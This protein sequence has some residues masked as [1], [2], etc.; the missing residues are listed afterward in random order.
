MV[1]PL[2]NFQY[3]QNPF[4]RRAMRRVVIAGILA[5]QTRYSSAGWT[6]CRSKSTGI[7][8]NWC[9]M[10]VCTF[11]VD[12]CFSSL[13]WWMMLPIMRQSE[14]YGKKGGQPVFRE[15]LKMFFQKVTFLKEKQL[16]DK[17]TEF[18]IYSYKK[19]ISIWNS[20]ITIEEFVEVEWC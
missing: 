20:P 9:L 2:K 3:G 5:M 11:T 15:L 4:I 17:I 10:K 14:C 12:D 1:G 18:A 13:T 8:R 16:G 19:A 6:D 7:G